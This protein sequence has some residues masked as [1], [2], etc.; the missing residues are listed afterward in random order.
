MENLHADQLLYVVGS[1][2][3]Q[4]FDMVYAVARMAGWLPGHVRC[5]H[6]S[7]GNVLGPDRKMFKT[8]SG[9]SVLLM[10]LVE[11]CLLYTSSG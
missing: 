5:E 4:H 6:V 2:Q 9:E 1:P 10:G 3:E 7:F 11:D 8:R